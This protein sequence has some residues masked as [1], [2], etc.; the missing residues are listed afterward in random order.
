M[1][2][3]VNTHQ[4]TESLETKP[5][6]SVFLPENNVPGIMKSAHIHIKDS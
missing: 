5:P 3:N 4:T 1:S 2:K 6:K